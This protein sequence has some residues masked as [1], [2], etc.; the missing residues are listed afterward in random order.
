MKIETTSAEIYYPESDGKPMG[1]TEWH[2]N[3]AI[4]IRDIMK[5]RYRGQRVYIGCDLFVYYEEGLP[6]H[7]FA[8]D[9]M[10]VKDCDT[11]LRPVFKVWEEGRP[12]SVVFELVSRG[13][14][15]EDLE[16]KPGLY[17]R[18]GIGEYFLYD[19][20]GRAIRPPLKGFRLGAAGYENIR[21]DEAGRFRSQELDLWL[22]VEDGDLI[23]Y[24]AATGQRLLTEAEFEHA[25]AEA[26]AA[27][28]QAE[29]AARQAAEQEIERLRKELGRQRP[30]N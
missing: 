24:D 20:R 22:R 12:P 2:V 19:P 13:T 28:L 8:P 10:V 30:A 1:E 17:E 9:V 6:Q 4:R 21:P 26:Q 29:R 11:H 27:A 16:F 15:R 23:F 25:A 14:R 5:Q 7:N 3:W 18:L